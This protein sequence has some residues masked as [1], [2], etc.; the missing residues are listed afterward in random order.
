[1]ENSINIK[2]L[3]ETQTK[4][5]ENYNKALEDISS[6]KKSLENQFNKNY[7]EL[8]KTKEGIKKTVQDTM[9]T[10]LISFKGQVQEIKNTVQ[11]TMGTELK[12]FKGQV[13][14]D[15]KET[16]T[17]YKTEIGQYTKDL[18][19]NKILKDIQAQI[20]TLTDSFNTLKTTLKN[21]KII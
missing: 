13:Q 20:K 12:N 4:L 7:Q 18:E 5:F 21:K 2:D 3:I 9:E 15:L 10:E 8:E 14:G 6:T 17:N 1:M 19:N 16:L 11:D